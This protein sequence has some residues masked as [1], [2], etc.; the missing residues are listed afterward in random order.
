MRHTEF[1][2]IGQGISGSFLG[3]W[4]QQ[5]HR[6]FIIIDNGHPQAASRVASGIINPVTGRRVVRTWMIGTLLP[7]AADA[8]R[9]IG[10]ALGLEVFSQRDIIDLFP[11]PQMVNAFRER[12]LDEADYL[13]LPEDPHEYLGLFNYHFGYGIVSPA[14][15]VH[16]AGLLTALRN[17]FA[18]R[19]QLHEEDFNFPELSIDRDGVSY[20]D[21]RAEKIIFC[22]G[23]P[24]ASNP[25]FHKLPF[26][27]SKGE[28]LVIRC[29]SLPRHHIFKKGMSL[30]PLGGEYF[31]VG[32]SYE[33]NFD[34]AEPTASFR[35]STSLILKNW[36]KP[37]FVVE[38]HVA[39]L[40]PGTLERRPFVGMHPHQPRL[41]LLNGMGTKGC[42]LAPYFAWQLAAHL[43]ENTPILAEAN[44]ARFTRI[45]KP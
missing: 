7:F 11:T 36:L 5:A 16:L 27:I 45:L 13:R 23:I 35:D 4:L 43:T 22:D 2:L 29:E 3:W 14:Y 44:L 28:A 39:A 10:T 20:R 8:Y 41:G 18:N 33:W 34:D 25:F 12:L 24:A 26:A 32:S 38:D 31:W 17:W 37:P 1:L 15:T 42:S 40:R 9:S 6:E 21:I 19:G 30:V